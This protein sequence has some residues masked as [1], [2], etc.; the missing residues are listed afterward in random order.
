MADMVEV[1]DLF[2]RDVEVVIDVSR[3]KEM[4]EEMNLE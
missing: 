3:G 2:D 4:D 1:G